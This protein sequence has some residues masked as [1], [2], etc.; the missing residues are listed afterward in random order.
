[1][2]MQLRE[3]PSDFSMVR[4]SNKT[5]GA[6][7]C[8]LEAVAYV[9]G[10]RHSD[11]PRCV[12]PVIS[13]FLRT[14]NDGLPG[15]VDRVR[16]LQPLIPDLIGTRANDVEQ[17]RHLLIHDW[18][19]RESLPLWL[20]LYEPLSGYA[21]G[22]KVL[23]E[24]D[25]SLA[26]HTAQILLKRVKTGAA[27]AAWKSTLDNRDIWRSAGH[28]SAV[29]VRAA[30]SDTGRTDVVNAIRDVAWA[31]AWRAAASGTKGCFSTELAE[32][33]AAR[34]AFVE[35]VATLQMSALGLVKRMIECGK[36]LAAV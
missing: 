29:A 4:G 14:W 25:D 12:C 20:E 33:D 5:S 28:E 15:D 30:A 11:H 9:S 13:S 23:P 8:V 2:N 22:F 35:T 16:L 17:R 19:V 10:E 3:L 36:G 34:D 24:I 6:N 1:M 18:L 26:E 7:M 21:K 27:D 31:V 32:V